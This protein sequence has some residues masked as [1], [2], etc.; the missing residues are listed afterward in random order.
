MRALAYPFLLTAMVVAIPTATQG[1]GLELGGPTHRREDFMAPQVV[2]CDALNSLSSTG[3]DASKAITGCINRTPVNGTLALPAGRYAIASQIKIMKPVTVKTNGISRAD[4]PCLSVSSSQCAELFAL[5]T[6][7]DEHG[8]LYIGADGTTIDHLVIDGNRLARVEH[9]GAN[10]AC[11][12]TADRGRNIYW[13]ADYGS[14]TNNVVKNALCG[15]GIGVGANKNVAIISNIIASNG[16]HD[17]E[18]MWADGLTAYDLSNSTIENNQFSDNTD[19]DLVLGGCRNCAVVGNTITHSDKF[20][21]AAFGALIIHAWPMT[22]GNYTGAIFSNNHID[23]GPAKGCGF[24]IAIGAGP[25]HQS[26]TITGA[27]VHDNTVSNAQMGL[28]IDPASSET[29]EVEVYDNF[30]T[31]SEVSHTG[32]DTR[33]ISSGYNITPSTTGTIHR[34]RD[35]TPTREYY[36][37][38]WRQGCIPNVAPSAPALVLPSSRSAFVTH[39]YSCVLNRQ[40]DSDGLASWVAMPQTTTLATFYRA[41]FS[42]YEYLARTTSDEK[43]V[44]QL[45]ECVLFLIPTAGAANA[46]VEE[47]TQGKRRSDLLGDFLAALELQTILFAELNAGIGFALP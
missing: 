10:S 24:G 37:L 36:N 35:T 47:L 1:D 32:C 21:S 5:P 34:Q 4:G 8:L 2:V 41:F 44:H 30:V 43:Y 6:F 18:M 13:V 12:S 33:T 15:T 11:T 7:N 31:N 17:Q 14:F 29:F 27:V 3:A 9:P 22:S 23:C 38:T 16:A 45:S 19:V 25:W 20:S 28:S 39:L 26:K 40:P 46:W 42:S